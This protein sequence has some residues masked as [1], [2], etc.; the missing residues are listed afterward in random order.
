MVSLCIICKD[1]EKDI[2]RILSRVGNYFDEIVITDTG[3][4]DKTVEIAKKYGA[5]VSTFKWNNNFSDARNFNFSQATSEWIFWMDTDDEVTGLENLE[6]LT[7]NKGVDGYAFVYNYARDEDGNLLAVQWRERLLRNGVFEWKG[8]LHETAIQK[9]SATIVRDDSIVVDHLATVEKMRVSNKRNIEILEEEIKADGDKVDPR[10]LYY[11]AQSYRGV[12]DFDNAA[13]YYVKYLEVGGWDEERMHAWHYLADALRYTGKYDEAIIADMEAIKI[14]PDWPDG[15][16]GLGYTYFYMADQSGDT[17]FWGKAIEWITNGFTKQIPDTTRTIEPMRYTWMPLLQ[18]AICQLNLGEVKKAFENYMKAY[19]MSNQSPF[20]AEHIDLFKEMYVNDLAA[21][22]LGEYISFLN[23]F[24]KSKLKDIDKIVSDRIGDNPKL[25]RIKNEATPPKTWADNSVV[26]YCSFSYEAWAA[27]SVIKGIGGSE[28]AVI[29]AARLWAKMGYDVTVFNSCKEL[30]GDYEG[31]KYRNVWE[32][33]PRDK[34]NVFVSWRNPYSFKQIKAKHRWVWLHDVPE[35]AK[36]TYTPQLL[37]NIDKIVVLSK[38]HKSLIPM[39]PNDKI[40]VSSNGIVPEQF[41]DMEKKPFSIF[42][43]SSYDRGLFTLLDKIYPLIKKEVPEATIDICY[44]W[45]T[46]E[47]MHAKDPQ[48]MAWKAEVDELMK[49]DGITHHGRVSHRKVAELMGRCQVH[50]Y[51]TEFTEINCITVQKAQCAGCFPVTT[52]V[53][54]LKETNKYGI[55]INTDSIYSNEEKQREF[56][57]AVIKQL[58]NPVK[59][60][61]DQAKKDFSWEVMAKQ[62]SDEWKK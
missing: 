29:N 18:L 50:A 38:Y 12:N 34:F 13:K 43:G 2:E 35:N 59:I 26:I 9:R 23:L 7:K 22:N 20:V 30:R 5:K 1:N 44:G 36:E 25:L 14:M 10:T 3:S 16:F 57:D 49:Q 51:P 40:L 60:D 52:N 54:A 48:A 37:S 46:F 33:N 55:K 31:V 42:Y 58:K 27:P 4:K 41:K 61:V 32:L 45:D 28:E 62:W 21:D 19:K 56:A 15:Y 8:K 53:A 47:K 39:V 24:D 17:K 11:A 6:N